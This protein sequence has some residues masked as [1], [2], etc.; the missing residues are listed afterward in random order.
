[1]MRLCFLF[2]FTMATSLGWTQGEALPHHFEVSP[3]IHSGGQPQGDAAFA[4]LS[5]MGVTTVISVDGARPDVEAASAH[6]LRYVHVPIGYDAVPPEASAAVAMV[7]ASP[8][9]V[10]YIHCHHGVHRGPAVAAIAGRI[11]GALTREQAFAFMQEA[12]TGTQY[13]GLWRDVSQFTPA[14]IEGLEVTL[15]EVAPVDSYSAQMAAI[16]RIWD[17]LILCQEAGWQVPPNHPD[18]EPKHEALMLWEA[19]REL[20]R[21]GGETAVVLDE[22]LAD[23]ETLSQRLHLIIDAGRPE[24]ADLLMQGLRGLC[25][26]CHSAHRN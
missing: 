9:E 12:E 18:V 7:L 20:R 25:R 11:T 8:E 26:D 16:D 4:Q 15:Y 14:L 2:I 19:F 3:R 13:E 6:G 21:T 1:M 17:R 5:D 22:G 24:Q 10:V 23:A